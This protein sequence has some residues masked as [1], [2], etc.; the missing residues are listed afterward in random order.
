MA[1]YLKKG[2]LCI[3]NKKS[4]E[5]DEHYLERV[6][7]ITNQKPTTQKEFDKVELYSKIYI[8]VKYLKC[9]YQKQVMNTLKD[10]LSTNQ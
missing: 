4:Y 5:P 9:T 10:Y 8:N 3:V 6:N 1:V 7:F 2:T